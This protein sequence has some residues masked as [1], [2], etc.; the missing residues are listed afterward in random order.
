MLLSLLVFLIAVLLLAAL[1]EEMVLPTSEAPF[2]VVASLVFGAAAAGATFFFLS[3][4]INVNRLRTPS[5]LRSGA[6]GNHEE[7]TQSNQRRW[8]W[9]WFERG[10]GLGSSAHTHL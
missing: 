1:I 2:D 10:R 6:P 3:R 7:P 5:M 8:R 4:E 9:R